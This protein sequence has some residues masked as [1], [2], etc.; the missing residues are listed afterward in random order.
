MW[1]SRRAADGNHQVEQ[2]LLP[3]DW[4]VEALDGGLVHENLSQVLT[5]AVV[6]AVVIIGI[7][8]V[9]IIVIHC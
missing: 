2:Q 7:I 1:G 8:V 4:S 3:E 5:V 9:I 6:V